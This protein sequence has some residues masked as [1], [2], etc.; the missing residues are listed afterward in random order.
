MPNQNT[1]F[2]YSC[3]EKINETNTFCPECGA[4]LDESGS[5][6][7]ESQNTVNKVTKSE[8]EE[9]TPDPTVE[10]LGYPFPSKLAYHLTWGGMAFIFL[11]AFLQV[12]AGWPSGTS[13]L[14]LLISGIGI[15]VDMKY[16]TQVSEQWQPNKKS[17]LAG[18]FLLMILAV[19]L[20]LYR[21]RK[22]I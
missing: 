9:S 22:Y 18:T 4:K 20:Y 12:F 3:G 1:I 10:W 17:Y 2:C 19:P 11:G 15:W 16:V 8:F 13:Y 21:R 14:G 5:T 7:S 6:E